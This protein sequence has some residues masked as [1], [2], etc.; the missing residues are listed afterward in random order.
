M[1]FREQLAMRFGISTLMVIIFAVAVVCGIVLKGSFVAFGIGFVALAV[2]LIE[3]MSKSGPRP[4]VVQ[5]TATE[6]D[7]YMLRDYLFEHGV[8][9]RVEGGR[10]GNIYPGIMRPRVLVAPQDAER[11]LEIMQELAK[12]QASPAATEAARADEQPSPDDHDA[13]TR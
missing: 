1:G 3:L 11:T 2:L 6:A 13:D 10:G 9:A 8:E 4:V 12:R 5:E 7:A